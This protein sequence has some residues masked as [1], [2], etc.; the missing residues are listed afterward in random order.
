MVLRCPKCS[1]TFDDVFPWIK[2]KN[3]CREDSVKH[4][5][6]TQVNLC[7]HIVNQ[8]VDQNAKQ[9]ADKRICTIC[10][11]EKPLDAFNKN[12]YR[13]KVCFNTKVKCSMCNDLITISNKSRHMKTKHGNTKFLGSQ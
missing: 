3:I 11:I 9:S 12:K 2:H 1:L 7:E 5:V 4:D 8:V 13:C 10:K 6:G